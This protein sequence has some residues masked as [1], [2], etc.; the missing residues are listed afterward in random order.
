MTHAQLIKDRKYT[1]SVVFPRVGL[2][3]ERSAE[4]VFYPHGDLLPLAPLSGRGERAAQ[5]LLVAAESLI[6]ADEGPL[7]GAWSIADTD[8]AMMLQRLVKSGHDVPNR[9]RTYA[10]AQWQRPAVREFVAQKR[11]PH[12]PSQSDG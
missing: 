6:P 11:P 5:K 12:R 8:L 9:V 7:F 1:R 10:D 2:R 4:Y 3:N